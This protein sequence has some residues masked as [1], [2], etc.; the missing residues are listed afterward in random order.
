MSDA[1]AP[2][3]PAIASAI[4]SVLFIAGRPLAVAD[5][6]KLLEVDGD[7]LAMALEWLAED[8]A[9]GGRGVRLQRQAEQVQLVSAPENARYV[10][11]LLGMPTQVKLTAG[12]LETLAV[13]AYRQPITRAQVEHI[14]GVNS[15]R[16]LATLVQHGFV[17][18]VG[19]AG[20]AG[21]PILFGTTLEF[22]QQFGLAGL[23][24]LPNVTPVASIAREDAVQAIR[25]AV[26]AGEDPPEEA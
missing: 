23:E 4:E 22:L 19:R 17:V 24:A 2:T 9:R 11:A 8:L 21:R 7:D 5:L 1:P 10:A 26:E 13:V 18:E 15:D 25:R 20:G 6:R 16:A 12:A 3:L 14:R